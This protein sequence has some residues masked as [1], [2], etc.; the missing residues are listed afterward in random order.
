MSMGTLIIIRLITI[1][2]GQTQIY[3]QDYTEDSLM[4]P[5]GHLSVTSRLFLNLIS[6]MHF[7][8]EILMTK[9]IWSNLMELLLRSCMV[10]HVIFVG[11]FI[12]LN[13]H[14]VYGLTFLDY[15]QKDME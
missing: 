11:T 3:R 6:R 8:M 5:K 9:S 14:L 10:K 2:K 1:V 13:N 12:A 7:L 15:L 4:L